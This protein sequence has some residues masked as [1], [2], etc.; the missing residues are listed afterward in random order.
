M[1]LT[2]TTGGCV[3]IALLIVF[4]HATKNMVKKM[5]EKYCPICKVDS[6]SK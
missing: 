3:K 5:Q 6:S 2:L 1:M 4:F